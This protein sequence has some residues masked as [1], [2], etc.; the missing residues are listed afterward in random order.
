MKKAISILIVLLL[1]LNASFCIAASMIPSDL[2]KEYKY[3]EQDKTIISVKERLQELGYFSPTALFSAT[4]GSS[5]KDAVKEFQK[6]NGLKQDGKL[7][8]DLFNVLFSSSA[9]KSSKTWTDKYDYKASDDKVA[10]FYSYD[11]SKYEQESFVTVYYLIKAMPG[12]SYN[13][14]ASSVKVISYTCDSNSN[15]LSSQEKYLKTESGSFAYFLS[16]GDSTYV[17]FYITAQNGTFTFFRS[18]PVEIGIKASNQFFP[19]SNTVIA[20]TSTTTEKPIAKPDTVVTSLPSKIKESS[21]PDVPNIFIYIIAVIVFIFSFSHI[22]SLIK[23]RQLAR[24]ILRAYYDSAKIGEIGK[25]IEL[26]TEANENDLFAIIEYIVTKA[27]TNK[28]IINGYEMEAEFRQPT[29]NN[30]LTIMLLIGVIRVGKDKAIALNV[31][32]KEMSIIQRRRKCNN[33]HHKNPWLISLQK[34][35]D[36]EAKTKQP[37]ASKDNE[38]SNS[39]NIDSEW[40]ALENQRTA[41]SHRESYISERENKLKELESEIATGQEKLNDE[42]IAYVSKQ[43]DLEKKEEE[44]LSREKALNE[45]ENNLKELESTITQDQAQLNTERKDYIDKKSA[46]ENKEKDLTMREYAISQRERKLADCKISEKQSHTPDK[47][48]LAMLQKSL[49]DRESYLDVRERQLTIQ[50]NDLDLDKELA[51]HDKADIEKRKKQLDQRELAISNR[52]AAVISAESEIN[53]RLTEIDAK[54]AQIKAS[55]NTKN[56]LNDWTMQNNSTARATLLL[57]QNKGNAQDELNIQKKL[58][59][60]KENELTDRENQIK[61]KQ[62][63]LAGQ[64]LDLSQREA[65]VSEQVKSVNERQCSLSIK[66][67][68][69]QKK[70]EAM[71]I[72]ERSLDARDKELI[73]KNTLLNQRE[74]TLDDKSAEID[75]KQ[76]S[77]TEREKAL[78]DGM[79]KLAEEQQVLSRTRSDDS[80]YQTRMAY[81]EKKGNELASQEARLSAKEKELRERSDILKKQQNDLADREN[82]LK[83]KLAEQER[84]RTASIVPD[85]TIDS[86]WNRLNTNISAAQQQMD[87]PSTSR[88]S[89]TH[90]AD[91]QP[92]QSTA[93]ADLFS[94]LSRQSPAADGSLL[95]SLMQKSTKSSCQEYLFADV[96]ESDNQVN[97]T[98]QDTPDTITNSIFALAFKQMN[99]CSSSAPAREYIIRFQDPQTG[100]VIS[101]EKT[102]TTSLTTADGIDDPIKLIF[103][104]ENRKKKKNGEYWM[105]I[106]DKNLGRI[107]KKYIFKINLL[108]NMDFDL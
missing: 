29:T 84:I 89:Q 15:I 54:K 102:I 13:N 14:V 23:A 19:K 31:T 92:I 51:K 82:A 67:D 20:D 77:L 45:R 76:A 91:I 6:T 80:S 16:E 78:K 87:L 49:E 61:A 56:A 1:I 55:A 3:G 107:I 81:L 26:N 70:T 86:F 43:K 18:E 103:Q 21:S 12:Y 47:G 22:K 62:Q 66:E 36:E 101:D 44:L 53:R 9:K 5:L 85:S 7:N 100:V 25:Y 104:L 46:L 94:A 69:L 79:A 32:T 64:E 33:R 2:K 65:V 98:L 63:Q 40:Q 88:A 17:I 39:E 95:G 99:P 24:K 34:E 68:S 38:P 74:K 75:K 8:T 96:E 11:K 48:D 71:S 93:P 106:I 108:I 52:E 27:S 60:R 41:L 73:N 58:L 105:V 50:Q 83:K 90:M 4:I 57:S 42:R 28:Y 30:L 10:V 37:A 97:L 59:Q 35:K 72:R